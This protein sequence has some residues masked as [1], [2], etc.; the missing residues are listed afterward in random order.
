[1]K[2]SLLISAFAAALASSVVF[3][4]TEAAPGPG[5]LSF[6]EHI[7]NWFGNMAT[8][9]RAIEEVHSSARLDDLNRRL[10]ALETEVNQVKSQAAQAATDAQKA[11]QQAEKAD[12]TATEAAKNKHASSR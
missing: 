12:Q 1:M 8:R 3:A 5:P 4:A 10:T 6:G 9:M 11:E 7:A 2:R